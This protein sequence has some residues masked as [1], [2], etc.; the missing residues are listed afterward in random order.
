MKFINAAS[1]ISFFLNINI[2]HFLAF[3]VDLY[4]IFRIKCRSSHNTQNTFVIRNESLEKFYRKCLHM[5]SRLTGLSASFI[6]VYSL[7]MRNRLIW[8]CHTHTHTHN[9][10]SQ[11][12]LYIKEP[13]A[14]FF[15]ISE[16]LLDGHKWK[17]RIVENWV[18]LIRNAGPTPSPAVP[19]PCHSLRQIGTS[20][21]TW[22]NTYICT[23]YNVD[24]E[25]MERPGHMCAPQFQQSAASSSGSQ[26]RMLER[27]H[28]RTHIHVHRHESLNTML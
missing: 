8:L 24:M 23:K 21:T 10:L 22:L 5:Q 27:T 16:I 19:P 15:V 28:T 13:A 4:I 25:A 26:R 7:N 14:Q 3:H 12:S 1:Y 9:K 17:V 11:R 2:F 6:F 18:V 20:G